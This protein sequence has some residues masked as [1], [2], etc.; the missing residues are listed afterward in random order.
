MEKILL[1][2]LVGLP[3]LV[4]FVAAACRASD[5]ASDAGAVKY[6]RAIKPVD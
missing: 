4:L 6:D 5:E 1:S 3:S 2:I